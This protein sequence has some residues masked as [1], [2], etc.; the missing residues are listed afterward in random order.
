MKEAGIYYRVST[1][2]RI[3]GGVGGRV[4]H[5]AYF[6]LRLFRGTARIANRG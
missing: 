2:D 6:S 3:V 5:M 4:A 1:L